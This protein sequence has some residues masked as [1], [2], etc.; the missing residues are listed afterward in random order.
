MFVSK[1]L[2]HSDRSLRDGGYNDKCNA[3]KCR[4]CILRHHQCVTLTENLNLDTIILAAESFGKIV[5]RNLV[6][7]F[8]SM[9]L[10]HGD[11]DFL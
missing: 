10:Y 1:I 8:S 9:H 4:K 3:A 5:D 7:T 11:K 6:I 2:F